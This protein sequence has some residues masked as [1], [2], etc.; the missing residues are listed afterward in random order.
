[1]KGE[2]SLSFTGRKPKKVS[3]TLFKGLKPF[4]E[5]PLCCCKPKIFTVGRRR[6]LWHGIDAARMKRMAS[7]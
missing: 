7:Q 3:E 6:Q 4:P 1:M 2:K 5:T